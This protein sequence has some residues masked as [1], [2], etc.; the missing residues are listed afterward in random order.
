MEYGRHNA[1]PVSSIG[2]ICDHVHLVITPLPSKTIDSLIKEIKEFTK[3]WMNNSF[4]GEKRPFDWQDGY[5]AFSA[6]RSDFTK[7]AN[8]ID[9]QKT[10]HE[11]LTCEE[12][13]IGIL[14]H[15][16]VEYNKNGLLA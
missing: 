3:T 7:L 15:N 16:G 2:G 6:S 8:Y 5:G 14:E 9:N 12:E 11:S 10:I 4:F 13:F 1:C